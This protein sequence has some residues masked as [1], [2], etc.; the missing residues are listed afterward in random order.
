MADLIGLTE[1]D[2]QRV[3][4]LLH[5]FESGLLGP[6]HGFGQL[7]EQRIF[8]VVR[9]RNDAAEAVPAYGL[10]RVNTPAAIDNES[11]VTIG[12]PDA[13]FRRIYLVNGPEAV[14]K[15]Q[16]GW[17]CWAWDAEWILYD[18]GGTPASPT[19]GE[20]W[21]AKSDS[22]KLWP[23]RPGYYV[24]GQ[25][26]SLG[27]SKR[28]KAFP[29]LVGQVFIKA[30][31][32]AINKDASGTVS[33]FAGTPGSETDTGQDITSAYNRTRNLASNAFGT[34]SWLHGKP[35]IAPISC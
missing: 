30:D 28:L 4:R 25:K 34:L 26:T 11:L 16:R 35:Y 20:E 32:G 19:L 31:H 3:T 23:N 13:T 27:G 24:T 17:G 10:M 15:G 6:D 5:S 21:G 2:A 29:W 18:D 7:H 33:V 1:R 12:K 14:P 22:W 9:F 8:E